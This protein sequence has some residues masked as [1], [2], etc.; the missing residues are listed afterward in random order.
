MS[1]FS[2]CCATAND[3]D[4]G[5]KSHDDS[6]L[7]LEEE[8]ERMMG[9]DP[10]PPFDPYELDAPLRVRTKRRKQKNDSNA[11]GS[12]SNANGDDDH[13]GTNINVHFGSPRS[14]KKKEESNDDDDDDCL[15]DV[16]EREHERDNNDDKGDAAEDSEKAKS[17]AMV[18][19]QVRVQ[20]K[21]KQSKKPKSKSK[22][23]TKTKVKARNKTQLSGSDVALSLSANID[24]LVQ[25]YA[26][27]NAIDFDERVSGAT[28]AVRLLVRL[29]RVVDG[30]ELRSIVLS[31]VIGGE[32]KR[33]VGLKSGDRDHDDDAA[34]RFFAQLLVG[35]QSEEARKDVF[36]LLAD[37]PAAVLG[38][39]DAQQE[40]RVLIDA[41]HDARDSVHTA[42]RRLLAQHTGTTKDLVDMVGDLLERY[43]ASVPLLELLR[44]LSERSDA[45][46]SSSTAAVANVDETRWKIMLALLTQTNAPGRTRLLLQQ[47]LS[48]GRLPPKM[49][50]RARF[51]QS[52]E[53][54]LNAFL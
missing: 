47:I 6:G 22:T 49:D 11:N 54:R 21:S 2:M 10:A 25:R 4:S 53:R 26:G 37:L 29:L 40:T 14:Q 27:G 46:A 9:I 43:L 30:E 3:V 1:M 8:E 35:L 31:R 36:S 15:V 20:L 12:E 23:K 51:L 34:E 18:P 28:S 13:D 39:E 19:A 24:D 48:S 5:R 16:D 32:R 33:L 42:R 17:M 7:L 44:A 52:L 50:A 45:G 41:T 38:D